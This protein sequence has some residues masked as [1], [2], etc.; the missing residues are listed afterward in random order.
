MKKKGISSKVV[1]GDDVNKVS[2]KAMESDGNNKMSF[3]SKMKTGYNP[4]EEGVR[5]TEKYSDDL[6]GMWR[7]MPVFLQKLCVVLAVALL[8]SSLKGE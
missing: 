6:E 3:W 7:R 8:G 1:N 4:M 2:K 5:W